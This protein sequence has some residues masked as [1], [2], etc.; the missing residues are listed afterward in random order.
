MR[1]NHKWYM[2]GQQITAHDICWF[3]PNVH[4]ELE[5]SDA[6]ASNNWF[7]ADLPRLRRV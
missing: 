7:S 5:C 1:R 4:V 6:R 3:D 2:S